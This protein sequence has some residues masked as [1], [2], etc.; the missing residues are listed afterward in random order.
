MEFEIYVSRLEE[1]P[2]EQECE[3]LIRALTPSDRRKKY[4]YQKVRALIS[5]QKDRYPDLL[6]VRFLKGQ[7]HTDPYSI[8]IANTKGATDE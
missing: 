3:L 1:L 5:Q 8:R 7:L 2:V 4:K 6:W